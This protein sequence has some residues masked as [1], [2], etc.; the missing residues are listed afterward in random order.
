MFKTL[1]TSW[2]EIY[3]TEYYLHDYGIDESQLKNRLGIENQDIDNFI[4]GFLEY[5]VKIN[6]NIMSLRVDY[7]IYGI[8]EAY[9]EMY[10]DSDSES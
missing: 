3:D 4:S 8:H 10:S 2:S 9:S 7:M 6:L 5:N 1:L